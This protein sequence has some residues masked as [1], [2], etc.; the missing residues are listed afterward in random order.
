MKKKQEILKIPKSQK[1]V[2]IK[3]EKKICDVE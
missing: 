1:G 3:T 2:N